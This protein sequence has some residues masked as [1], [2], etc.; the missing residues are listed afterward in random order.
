M[1]DSIEKIVSLCK[2]RGFIFPGSEIYG[3]LA[4]SWDY[5]PLGVELKNNIKKLWWSRFVHQRQDIVGLDAAL[6]MNPKVWEASGHLSA[7]FSDQLVECKNC[8]E[9][10]RADQIENDKACPNCDKKDVFT[11]PKQFNL[12]FKTFIGPAEEKANIAY[13]RPETAQGMFVDFKNVLDTSRTT[14]P[15]G[16]A[17]IGKAFRNEITPG[18][19]IFRTREFEQMEIEYFIAPP[20]DDNDWQSVFDMWREEMRSWMEAIGL[21]LAHIHELEVPE[22]ERAHYSKR[23]IDFEYDF[24]FGH[25]ELYG[26]A[27]RTD[28]DL[29]N[30]FSQPPYRDGQTGDSYWPHVIEPTWGVDRSALA[31]LCETYAEDGERKILKLKPSLAPY[32]AAIFPLLANKPDLVAKAR[33]IYKSLVNGS[34]SIVPIAWDDRGNIGKRYYSQDEIGTPFCITVDF[35]TLE[36]NTVTVRNRDTT[37]QIRLPGEKLASHLTENL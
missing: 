29:K 15:F 25:K 36:D 3:G 37:K 35:Q 33:E 8:H 1:T 28:F 14:V 20:K 11:E 10:F 5:G 24:P 26:L 2:R 32:K 21:D 34:S 19:F 27:Y 7:G 4:N 22:G 23:T 9:R 17:Q 13:L 6:I 31:V 18:N 16:I 12:M 30:H